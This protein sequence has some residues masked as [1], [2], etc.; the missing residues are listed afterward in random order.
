MNRAVFLDRDGVINRKAPEGEYVTTW[1]Q[2]DLLPD[3]ADG[4]ALLNRAGFRVIVV[5]NQRCVAKGLISIE[6]LNALHARLR[7]YLESQFAVIDDIYVCPHDN[8]PPC[9]CRKPEPGMLMEAAREH[10]LDILHSWMIGDSVA[11]IEAG[12]AAGCR[13]VMIRDDLDFPTGPDLTATSL[14]EAAKLI[15]PTAD[16]AS[17]ELR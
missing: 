7:T 6:E 17:N 10:D 15:V 3:V 11:D 5:T 2:M 12:K 4:I 8:I 9:R 14:L 16:N 13:T 1:G